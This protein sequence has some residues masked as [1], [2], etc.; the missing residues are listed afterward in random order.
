MG[1][2]RVDIHFGRTVNEGLTQKLTFKVKSEKCK[3][4]AKR[5]FQMEPQVQRCKGRNGLASQR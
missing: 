5:M 1:K 2:T 3:E 4:P